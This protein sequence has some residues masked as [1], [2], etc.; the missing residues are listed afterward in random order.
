M[1]KACLNSKIQLIDLPLLDSMLSYVSVSLIAL[2]DH[3]RHR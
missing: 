1:L 3:C 2:S